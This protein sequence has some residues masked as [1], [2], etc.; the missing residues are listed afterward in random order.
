MGKRLEEQI[1]AHALQYKDNYYR[2][3]YS[4]VRNAEDALDIVQEAVYKAMLSVR[5][6]KHPQYLRTW[7]YRIVVNTSLDFLR[8]HKK[9]ELVGA[10]ALAGLDPGRNDTYTDFD[11][12]QALDALPE[13]YR[14][15]VVL[16]FFD[17]LKIE[18]IAEILDENPNTVKSRLYTA[19]DKLRQNLR[20]DE[21]A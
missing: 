3:A 21:E 19:L 15:V 12:R 6:L 16:R 10:E 2:L 18:E 8:R 1:A 17:D 20:D 5:S 13:Q 7:F 4:Y 11:L 9:T 14:T